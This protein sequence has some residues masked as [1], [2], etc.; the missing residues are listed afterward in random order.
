MARDRDH[1]YLSNVAEA[2][3]YLFRKDGVPH[4][5]AYIWKN[6][7]IGPLAVRAPTWLPDVLTSS[8]R[9]ALRGNPEQVSILVT[10]SN[11]SAM[12]LALRQGLR[13]TTPFLW[14]SSRSMGNP[15]CY[16]FYSPGF[17]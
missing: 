16:L 10:G 3:C 4:G 8:F 9:L 17:M 1:S 2:A 7:R 15:A 5:Y 11:E 14:M 13:I 6:G 12:A